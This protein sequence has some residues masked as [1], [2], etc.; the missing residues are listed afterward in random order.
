M[1]FT[2]DSKMT[3]ESHDTFDHSTCNKLINT[4]CLGYCNMILC[5][6]KGVDRAVLDFGVEH[7]PLGLAAFFKGGQK[8]ELEIIYWNHLKTHTP[9]FGSNLAS[10]QETS[11]S[12][13]GFPMC[14]HG[15]DDTWL[16]QRRSN[17][18]R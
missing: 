13:G 16:T 5:T 3:I 11:A 7:Y 14:E 8:Q 9:C 4:C 12:T 15:I 10:V 1:Y 2:E 17:T 6:G 18:K